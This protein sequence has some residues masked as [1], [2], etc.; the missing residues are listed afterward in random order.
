MR[1]RVDDAADR[2]LLASALL[3]AGCHAVSVGPTLELPG[4]GAT[5][6]PTELELRFFV[7][8]W[9]DRHPTARL[10]FL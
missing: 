9:L 3:E 8:A 1:I 4:D 10:A 6:E 7:R 2:T 5:D